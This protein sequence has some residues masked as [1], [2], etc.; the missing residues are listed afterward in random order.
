MRGDCRDCRRAIVLGWV[1]LE[2]TTNA[3]KGRCST[4]ELPT[5]VICFNRLCPRWQPTPKAFG[6]ALP[7]SYQPAER[8]AFNPVAPRVQAIGAFAHQ[9]SQIAERGF[10]SLQSEHPQTCSLGG[11]PIA[12]R[13]IADV[14]YLTRGKSGNA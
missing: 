10:W 2:P 11:L 14:H 4:I 1:G 12:F 13:I 7:L 9:R 6:A 3:L 8:S 5:P